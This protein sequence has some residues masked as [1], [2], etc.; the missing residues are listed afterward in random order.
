MTNYIGLRTLRG[1]K[2]RMESSLVFRGREVGI[3]AEK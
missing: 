2:D 1:G 3:G